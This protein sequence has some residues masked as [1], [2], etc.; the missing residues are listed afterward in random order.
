MNADRKDREGRERREAPGD[1]PRTRILTLIRAANE[2]REAVAH[3]GD[4]Q[5]WR[6]DVEHRDDVGHG[7]ELGKPDRPSE[8]ESSAVE[9][10]ARR[11]E[12]AGGEVVRVPDRTSARDWLG[13]F[14]M[15]F[16]S[17]ALG[18]G[19]REDLRPDRPEAESHDAALAVSAARGAVAE[20]GSLIMDARDGRRTQ[21]LT[22]THVVVLPEDRVYRSL[23][24]ALVEL[25]DD[26]PAAVGLHSGPSKSADIG[27]IMVKGVH[28]PGRVIAVLI[29]E[30]ETS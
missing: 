11:F 25:K 19:V 18:T 2:G 28:G 21:L 5:G 9:A 7:N 16:D 6:G 30:G 22:P 29:R 13:A 27:Q 10:F 20:T 26:L 24:E 12:G 17:V 8:S 4:F 3:P 1:T 15:D 14:A 23:R